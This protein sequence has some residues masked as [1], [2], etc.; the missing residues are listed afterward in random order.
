[1]L[2][3][4]ICERPYVAQAALAGKNRRKTEARSYRHRKKEGH[5]SNHQV[6]ARIIEPIVW[7]NVVRFLLN[8]SIIKV[9]YEEALEKEQAQSNNKLKLQSQFLETLGK[10][11]EKKQNLISAYTDPEIP[12]TKAEYIEARDL[13]DKEMEELEIRIQDIEKNIS[14]LPTPE[15]LESLEN[16]ANEI[17]ATLLED[18]MDFTPDE[19]KHILDLLQIKVYINRDGEG[20]IE[21]W[22]QDAGVFRLNHIDGGAARSGEDPAG[23]GFAGDPAA[24]VCGRG[25]GCDADLLDRRPTP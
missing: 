15:E 23:A 1:M 25:S 11:K 20:R 14:S 19:K 18:E 12:M 22:F 9:G 8:P 3:C 21:S 5:C 24:D 17:R 7:D 4:D 16:F 13:I 6:S 10:H 2:F